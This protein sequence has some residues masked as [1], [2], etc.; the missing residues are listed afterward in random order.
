MVSSG[1]SIYLEMQVAKRLFFALYLPSCSPR[2]A[3][4]GAAMRYRPR[5][6]FRSMLA[7][8]ALLA[9]DWFAAWVIADIQV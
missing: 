3:T 7:V 6:G 9:V 8:T 4:G 5:F 1:S 2:V